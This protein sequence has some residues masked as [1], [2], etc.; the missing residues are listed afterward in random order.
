VKI[1]A[2]F[3]ARQSLVDPV[4]PVVI[5][6][7]SLILASSCAG[8]DELGSEPGQQS[9]ADATPDDVASVD[10]GV[11]DAGNTGACPR[12]S[13]L[14]GPEMVEV[15]SPAGT[16]YCIDSTE[17]TQGQYFEFLKAKGADPAAFNS[18]DT[19]GQ[20]PGCEW[21]VGYAPNPIAET[22]PSCLGDG[23]LSAAFDWSGQH[24]ENPV[25]CVDWCDA[26]MYCAWTGKHLCGKIGGGTLDE[27]DTSNAARSQWYNACSQGGNT[28]YPYGDTF[29]PGRCV[30]S[31]F[32]AAHTPPGG[33]DAVTF[34][35]S[36]APDCHGATSPFDEVFDLSGNV[37]EWTDACKTTQP[38]GA[39]AC[40][41]VAPA[42][43]QDEPD[44]YACTAG[45]F[46][47]RDTRASMYG[48]RCCLD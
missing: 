26:Y 33:S 5:S 43:G 3:G 18:G 27:A 41:I 2:G 46:L 25:G 7:V 8:R 20:P 30:D 34:P 31:T 32:A 21:N 39:I 47:S 9:T 15:P 29:D 17:V 48:F 6:L 24:P 44:M 10:Q 45:D 16:M 4:S 40:F 14:P 36:A 42:S 11:S 12:A 1:A 38:P 22:S 35:A 19:S 23:S 13:G 37:W 28:T